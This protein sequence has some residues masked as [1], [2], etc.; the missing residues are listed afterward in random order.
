MSLVSLLVA[1][2]LICLCFWA[3][4]TILRSFGIGDPIAGLVKVV[5]MI[6]VVLWALSALGFAPM[7]RLR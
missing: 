4:T 2:V 6:V 1:L 7:L 3:V 5:F